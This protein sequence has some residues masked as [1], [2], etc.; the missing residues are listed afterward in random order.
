MFWLVIRKFGSSCVCKSLRGVACYLLMTVCIRS[1][2]WQPSPSC[3]S[4]LMNNFTNNVDGL[5]Q[6][7]RGRGGRERERETVREKER[8]RE[9]KVHFTTHI[10]Y[11]LSSSGVQCLLRCTG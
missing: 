2:T 1:P 7:E 8:Y 4:K 9:I 10:S 3:L 6:V 11:S 5:V